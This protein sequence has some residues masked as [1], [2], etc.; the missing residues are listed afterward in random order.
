MTGRSSGSSVAFY[1]HPRKLEEPLGLRDTSSRPFMRHC[2]NLHLLDMATLQ[3]TQITRNPEI[4]FKLEN[5]LPFSTVCET[6]YVHPSQRTA[7][8]HGG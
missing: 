1:H 4:T 3:I 7:V 8:V 6:E 2:R 5:S